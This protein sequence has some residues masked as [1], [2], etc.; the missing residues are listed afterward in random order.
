MEQWQRYQEAMETR[1]KK[2]SLQA[3]ALWG[4]WILDPRCVQVLKK[5]PRRPYTGG[6]PARGARSDMQRDERIAHQV[7]DIVASALP[8]MLAGTPDRA[9]AHSLDHL[10]SVAENM[11]SIWDDKDTADAIYKISVYGGQMALAV[12]SCPWLQVGA[13]LTPEEEDINIGLELAPL[14]E[15][16]LR[17]VSL[18]EGL[19]VADTI[20]LHGAR[21]YGQVLGSPIP[22]AVIRSV[23][24]SA[25]FFI[26]PFPH[27]GTSMTSRTK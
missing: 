25:K 16:G 14:A 20:L 13:A 15:V 2:M 7:L 17:G 10:I 26:Y 22:E 11:S 27:T 8:Q 6:S 19:K 5:Y 12:D 3:A 4:M 21:P 24:A 9:C 23:L 1:L 18:E